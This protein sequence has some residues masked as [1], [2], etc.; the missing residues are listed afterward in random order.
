MTIWT[1]QLLALAPFAFVVGII[2][3]RTNRR[4]AA[5]PSSGHARVY[6]SH[7]VR[8]RAIRRSTLV[9]GKVVLFQVTCIGG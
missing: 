4:S 8:P 2:V 6:Q 7:N 5:A 9:S 1:A 3:V